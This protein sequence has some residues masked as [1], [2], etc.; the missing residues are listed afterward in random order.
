MYHL[1][2]NCRSLNLTFPEEF[3]GFLFSLAH[4]SRLR[5][6]FMLLSDYLKA[7][8]TFPIKWLNFIQTLDNEQTKIQKPAKKKYFSHYEDFWN[9]LSL[10]GTTG[11]V[12][13]AYPNCNSVISIHSLI[14]PLHCVR[15]RSRSLCNS[16]QIKIS[17]KQS[18]MPMAHWN[19]NSGVFCLHLI[20]I[21]HR[22]LYKEDQCDSFERD[23][24]EFSPNMCRALLTYSRLHG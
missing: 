8:F 17:S 7:I 12:K 15:V 18:E 21:L 3:K 4:F 22:L 24:T 5:V 16:P 20:K 1:L 13:C 19:D 14:S 9:S 10:S 6:N 11:E 23:K 2:W